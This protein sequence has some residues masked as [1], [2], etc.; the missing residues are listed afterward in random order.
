MDQTRV[1]RIVILSLQIALLILSASTCSGSDKNKLAEQFP[2]VTAEVAG[3][4]ATLSPS[5]TIKATERPTRAPTATLSATATLDIGS[6]MTNPIDGAEMVYVP[7]GEFLMGSEDSDAESDEG[8]EHFVYLDAFWI[9]KYEVKNAQ[10]AAFIAETGYETEAE[11][12]GYGYVFNW[13]VLYNIDGAYWAEPQGPGSDIEGLGDH[14]VI[15]V[16]WQDANEYCQWASGRLPTEAEWEKAARGEDGRKYSWGNSDISGVKANYC[17]KNCIY[18][19]QDI[20]QDDGYERT[21]P[22][23]SYQDGVSPYGVLDMAGNVMEFVYDWQ[24]KDYYASSPGI[25]PTGPEDGR[26][27]VIR[28]GAWCTS[29]HFL[30]TWDRFGSTPGYEDD[31]I[32]CRCSLSPEP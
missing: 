30:T 4:L 9:Y 19:W 22:V 7:A 17:D 8:P 20:S 16:T 6:S 2:S 14:P 13:G 1:Q 18:N 25:N 21:A 15:H 32:G 12:I 24:G 27:H 3:G 29:E 10:F 26:Y 23:G 31:T 5:P 11:E 28:G